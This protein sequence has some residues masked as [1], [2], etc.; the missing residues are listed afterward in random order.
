M[1]VM[2]TLYTAMTD[3]E[4]MYHEDEDLDYVRRQ[5]WSDAIEGLYLPE[6]YSGRM[7]TAYDV[8]RQQIVEFCYENSINLFGGVKAQ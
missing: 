3:P 7:R 4:L 5:A 6:N 2:K 8:G 1:G